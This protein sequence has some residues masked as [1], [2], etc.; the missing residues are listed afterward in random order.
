MRRLLDQR[1]VR[2]VVLINP[3]HDA[4]WPTVHGARLD[5]IS[6]RFKTDVASSFEHVC[7]YFDEAHK[8]PSIY[9]NTDPFHYLPAAGANMVNECLHRF[10]VAP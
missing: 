5:A 10:G 7:D 8:E 1:G 9:Y 2:Y 3:E 6:R 4:F